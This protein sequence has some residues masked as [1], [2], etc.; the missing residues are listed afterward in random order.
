MR[1]SFILSLLWL[2]GVGCPAGSLFA[3]RIHSHNDYHRRLP[4]YQAYAQRVQSIE[5]DVFLTGS[6]HVLVGHDQGELRPDRTLEALYIQPIVSVFAANG[7]RPWPD[8]AS[9]MVLLIDLKT[10]AAETL[11]AVVALLD[12]FP[13][14]FD[15]RVNPAAVQV[16]ISGDMPAPADFGRY[17]DYIW[18]DGRLDTSY[19][20]VALA[21]VAFFSMPFSAYAR[22]DGDAAFAGPDRQRV[23]TAIDS[24]HR[25]GKPIRFWGTPDGCTAWHT[26]F[27]MGV[28][29]INT[30]QVEQCAAFFADSANQGPVGE[31]VSF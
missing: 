13:Q 30:D 1:R 16:V 12:R 22:W 26:F 24:A 5:A 10:S 18:F 3:Q 25:M 20:D 4:F 31:P 19:T 9:R 27:H 8:S 21:R 28:D 14:V 7:G 11:P 2:A 17:P 29:I 23:Q 15:H 6:G